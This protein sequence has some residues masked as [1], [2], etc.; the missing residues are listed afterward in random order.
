METHRDL[1]SS[2]NVF[3]WNFWSNTFSNNSHSGI[4]VQLPDTY[5]LLEKKEH[6]FLVE[7]F[8]LIL[9]SF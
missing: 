4:S 5:D 3:H 8:F 2:A 7:N 9:T 1:Y 6:R